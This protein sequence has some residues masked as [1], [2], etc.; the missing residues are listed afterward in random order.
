[1]Q[2]FFEEDGNYKSGLILKH[3]GNAYQVELES[4]KRTKVKGGHVLFE[5]D[6]DGA[7]FLE[8]AKK[9]E[10]E[11][12]PAFLW[13]ASGGNEFDCATLAGEYFGTPTPVE[14]AATF[15]VLR[16]N[17]VYFYKKGRGIFKPAPKETLDRALEALEKRKR[18][19]AEKK[20]MTAAM[21]SGTVPEAI[22]QNAFSLLL[23]PDKNSIEWKALND[24]SSAE[25]VSP[26]GLLLQLGA[27]RSPY[28]WHVDGFYFEYFSHGKS[29][30]KS[31]PA[32]EVFDENLTESQA[33]AF[34]ID[35]SSTTEIDDAVSISALENGRLRLG[36]HIA[37][38]ALLIERDSPLDKIAR[39]RMS[40]VYGPGIKTTM[41]P[42]EW[43][44]A[45]SLKA[46]SSVPCVSLYAVL[47]EETMAVL[48][49]ET[50]VERVRIEANLR[51]DTFEED[52]TQEAILAGT[53]KM[54]YAAEIGMLWRFAKARQHER[55]L[56]RGR[57]ET[58]QK[59]WYFVLDGE[60]ENARAVVKSRVRGAPIDLVV[61]ELMIFANETWGLWLEEH[62]VA[63]IYRSQRLGRVKMSTTPG[64]H[65]GLGVERY[66]W[67]TSPL[68]RYVDLLNQR[69][70][71]RTAMGRTPAYEAKDTDLYTAVTAFESAYE[72]YNDFQR[73]M[74]RY[75][76]LR[77]IEQEKKTQVTALVVKDELVRIEGLPMMQR[78][79]GLPELERGRRIRLQ[80]L[81]CDYIELVLETKLLE[82]LDDTGFVE[83]EQDMCAQTE[84]SGEKD[85]SEKTSVVTNGEVR[86]GATS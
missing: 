13:E 70:I 30:P 52:V 50:C 14:R 66:A 40:T 72:A 47:D 61:S 55:E 82:V 21:L 20:A 75:W 32:P 43:V 81:G 33:R 51:Y 59:E 62:H 74:E 11:L 7:N 60:G 35:D 73:K 86:V 85:V 9:V 36:I 57:P 71:V 23:R 26:L 84:A 12:D 31:L 27:I 44:E 24:A 48:S 46:G 53:L 28:A 2:L 63:G 25:R 8:A 34:S 58:M 1:M 79:P 17:P 37:A 39:E 19:E 4:G 18:L 76:S 22:R 78:I 64:P 38:P 5:F 10:S 77:W 54:A 45:A 68:R 49:T 29:F 69:Q 16:N 80:I 15:L 42:P 6:Y 67:S 56:V 3:E 41:L 83:E 65:D